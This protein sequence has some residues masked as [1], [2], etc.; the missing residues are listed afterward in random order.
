[1]PKDI[2][3]PARERKMKTYRKLG[4]AVKN[5]GSTIKRIIKKK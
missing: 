2:S 5:V 3:K 1:M 4:E